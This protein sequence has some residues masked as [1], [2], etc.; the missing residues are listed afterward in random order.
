MSDDEESLAATR[1]RRANAGSR[2][3]Q[4][5]ALE[6]QSSD[7]LNQFVTE[8][9]ENVNLLFQEDENDDEFIDEDIDNENLE[10]I[11]EEDDEEGG[12]ESTSHKRT[13]EEVDEEDDDDQ[14]ETN[15]N[16]DDVLSDSDLS[17]SDSDESE[18]EKELQKQ[19]RLKKRRTKTVIPT[20]KKASSLQPKPKKIKK[21]NLITSDSLLLSQ[22]RSS[23]RSAAIENKQALVEKLKQSE[24]R[25]S[26]LAPVV[27]V[28]QVELTQEEKLAEA[29]ETERANVESLIRFQE[30]EIFKKE[31][32]KNMFLSKR[33]KLRNVIRILSKDTHITPLEE[34]EEFRRIHEMSKKKKVG[35]RKKNQSEEVEP[36]I[37]LPGDIDLELPLVKEEMER[38][39]IEKERLEKEAQE[40]AELKAKL[41]ASEAPTE[42]DDISLGKVENGDIDIQSVKV[43]ETNGDVLETNG[44]ISVEETP[45]VAVA[46]E[47]GVILS[48]EATEE[49]KSEEGPIEVAEDSIENIPEEDIKK[50]EQK[51]Q[52]DEIAVEV[53]ELIS[54]GDEIE[55]EIGHTSDAEIEAEIKD[56]SETN[57]EVVK[58]EPEETNTSLITDDKE[59]SITTGEKK[60][61]FLDEI[62]Q[63]N[64]DELKEETPATDNET[65][66]IEENQENKEIFEGPPQRISRNTIFL[67][68]FDED[69][70]DFKLSNSS[71]VKTILFG[72]QS[73]LPA[74]RRFKDIK[75]I[76]KIGGK[77]N[78]Y[79]SNGLKS[80]DSLFESTPTLTAD[81]PMFEE[82]K[83]LPRLGVKQD[84]FE[85][86]EDIVET[87]STAIIIK[88]EAPTGLYLPNGNKKNCLISGTEVKYFDPS[89]GIPYSSVEAYRILKL[90][91]Q[92]QIPWYS[93]TDDNNDTGPVE[94]YLGSRDGSV[95][96]A[97]GVPE[98]FEG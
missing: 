25:R 76:I 53:E 68:D 59:A 3:K 23:S 77:T 20:I 50:E 67:L 62:D 7:H 66:I 85:E 97:K 91:E 69:N 48:S 63:D 41:L 88:T 65:T 87:E 44:V 55:N 49:T 61:K 95:K 30:Q 73:L 22:R 29:V 58:T 35:R 64:D 96:H 4:L 92:G 79:E 39:R 84:L 27:R 60:V 5:I 31:K 19:E 72:A 78:P 81:D 75:T 74:S 34:I 45:E 28:Q 9:D 43:E 51:V 40:E 12:D 15:V 82:L 8:D 98:G 1:S 24:E 36:Y 86:V 33:L 71:N 17:M 89:T 26:K 10:G 56:V 83:R 80:E 47:D 18:G 2:L 70:K 93:L 38:E 11:D 94:I 13:R 16:S 42:G 21:T 14:D 37:R 57:G 6:E 52:E 90:I 32:Q 54:D 46:D